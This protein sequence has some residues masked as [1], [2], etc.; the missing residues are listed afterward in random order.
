[1]KPSDDRINHVAHLIH[2]RLYHEDFV[3][4]PDED[5]AL[6]EIKKALIHFFQVDEEADQAA[7]E[8][9]ASLKRE[10][11]PGSREWEVLYRKYFEEELAKR[12][13]G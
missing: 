8:K 4:Y 1:M 3:D 6:R 13:R 5:K 7:Q 9:I 10:V 12:G 11:L 2:D